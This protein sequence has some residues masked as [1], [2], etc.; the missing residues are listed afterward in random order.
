MDNAPHP[1]PSDR[2]RL[3][4]LL[5][6]W[7]FARPY[8]GLI[9]SDLLRR[10]PGHAGAARRPPAHRG[11]GRWADRPRRPGGV[12]PAA[13]P[14]PAVR[15]RRGGA[16]LPAPLGDEPQLPAHRARPAR[17]PLPAAA[18]AAGR[19]PR[20]VG[21]GPAALPRHHRR[22]HGPSL[23]RLR[24]RVP[25]G[26]PD[27]VRRRP[28]AAAGHVLAAG[29]DGPADDGA[30]DL[31]RVAVGE[32]VQHPVAPGAGP[33]GR[34][35]HRRRGGRA[36]HPRREVAGPQ[37][38]GVRPLRR[39]GHRAPR[40]GAGEGPHAGPA[41]V[42]LR[43]APAGDARGDP[44]RRGDG[45]EHRRAD[46]RRAGRLRRAVHRPA[47]ADPVAGLPV[48][49]RPGD[50]E[51][52]RPDRRAARRADHR[53]RP[54]RGPPRGARLPRPPAVPGRGLPLPGV[55]RGGARR[56]R[57]RHRT[58]R[59]RGAGRLDRIGQD[60]AHRAGRAAL[61]RHRR[62]GHRGRRRRARPAAEPA[63]QRRVGR[64]SRTRRC[65]R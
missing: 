33:A 59:D 22:L 18:A 41:V 42:H 48:R 60:D 47:V 29:A 50:G 54:A 30:A 52:L 40:H 26:Q 31:P 7:P 32:A 58:G 25:R 63:A 10:A 44:R 13:R 14:G 17:R 62:P 56:D 1:A 39:Q 34:A 6:L 24:G 3:S 64:P 36:G 51:R 45:G 2:G 16:V 55:G 20:P 53:H 15:R 27:H 61:R 57:P 9:A 4:A 12:D 8:R 5:R 19:L 11:R 37:R 46:R 35:D 38:P 49:L 43:A 28:R 23:R 65:S 21:L